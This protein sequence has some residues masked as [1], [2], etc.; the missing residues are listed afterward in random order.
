MSVKRSAI[1][2][3]IVALCAPAA[4]CNSGSGA[5]GEGRAA[6]LIKPGSDRVIAFT[7]QTG[8]KGNHTIEQVFVALPGGKAQQLTHSPDS[9]EALAWTSDGSRLIVSQVSIRSS[10]S[11]RTSLV[12]VGIDGGPPVPLARIPLGFG[13][14]VEPDCV[15]RECGWSGNPVSP[16]GLLLLLEGGRAAGLYVETIRDG[17]LRRLA[18]GV[19]EGVDGSSVAWSPD[20]RRIAYVLRPLGINPTLAGQVDITNFDGTGHTIVVHPDQLPGFWGN[21]AKGPYARGLPRR[22]DH[23]FYRIQ[24]DNVEWSRDG[25]RLIYDANNR[26]YRVNADG[27][28]L[29]RLTASAPAGEL[30]SPDGSPLAGSNYIPHGG[31]AGNGIGWSPNSTQLAVVQDGAIYVMNVDGSGLTQVTPSLARPI[32][33]PI[34]RPNPQ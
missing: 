33:N 27:S 8:T 25:S 29:T 19:E 20:G 34:W 5:F 1:G 24:P 28:D 17:S 18:T 32:F 15:T 11:Y 12:T 22:G 4:A 26:F 2:L 31:S 14:A 30:L 23:C 7:A 21:C 9:H 10:F 13:L 6:T 16:D 3:V